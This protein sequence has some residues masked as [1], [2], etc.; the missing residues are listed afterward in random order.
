MT[1]ISGRLF[2]S[3]IAGDAA[4]LAC[5]YGFGLEIA[6]FCTAFNMDTAFD[7]WD[8]RVRQSM[9]GVDRFIFHAP[10]N[11]LCPAAVDPLIVD[12]AKKRY[13]QAYALMSGYGVSAMIVH[14]GFLPILYDVGWFTAKSIEFW[15]DFLS[16]K[17]GNFTLYIENVYEQTPE[18][19]CGIVDAV[20]DTRLRLCL[21]VG[22][23]AIS[24]KDVNVTEWV[25]RSA[26]F[27]GHIHL[28]NNDGERDLH[29]TLGGG[30]IDIAA[31]IRAA[32]YIVPNVTFTIESVDSGKSVDWLKNNGFAV[33]QV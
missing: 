12:V 20:G 18:L 2:L 28:H 5:E 25:K 29:G 23:A 1:D 22:H 10:F 31:L 9:I 11:E 16:D 21:D 3:T 13:T 15:R 30:Q 8:E 26:P 6:E 32:I 7:M 19:L 24:A 14:S 27:L 4:E 33:Y 17:P